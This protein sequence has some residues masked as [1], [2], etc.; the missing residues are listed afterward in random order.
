M[1]A[2]TPDRLIV[3]APVRTHARRRVQHGAYRRVGKPTMDLFG[4]AVLLVALSPVMA[5]VALAVRLVLGR[6]VL[7]RQARVGQ[8][9]HTFLILKFRTMGMDR[10][11][12]TALTSDGPERRVTH[13]SA[14]DPRLVPLGR[15][16]RRWSLDE[17]PQLWNVLCGQM[18]LVGPRPELVAVVE[19]HGL[20]DH[21]RHRVKPGITGLWQVTA[22]ADGPLHEHV[23]IDLVYLANLSLR[24]D[25]EILLRT[26]TAALGR[27]RGF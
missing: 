17:L 27:G 19:R 13:K 4:A 5:A 15:F 9:G 7:F 14:A 26:P 20:R 22:R 25:V 3:P 11:E 2:V 24:Q 10:R 21:P 16:L 12:D 23:D 8:H 6:P 1:S 18:S